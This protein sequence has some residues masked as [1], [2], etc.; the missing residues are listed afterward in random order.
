MNTVKLI[1]T[2]EFII[3][4]VDK[5]GI[6]LGVRTTHF[7]GGVGAIEVTVTPPAFGDTISVSASKIVFSIAFVFRTL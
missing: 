7:I 2:S 6:S 1:Q 3:R 4:A 5:T